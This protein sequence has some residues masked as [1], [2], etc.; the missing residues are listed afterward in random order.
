MKKLKEASALVTTFLWIALLFGSLILTGCA[1]PV[2]VRTLKPEAANRSLTES[3]LSDQSLSA[4]TQQVLNRSGLAEQFRK[5]PAA[6]IQALRSGMPTVLGSGRYFALAELSFL[7]ASEGGERSHYL[8][9][10]A[11]AYAFLFPRDEREVPDSFDPRLV[12]AVN[13][14]NQGLAMGF[15]SQ[16]SE[17]I[18]LQN[19][20]R[21]LPF[22]K[23]QVRFDPAERLWGPFNLS[24]FVASSSYEVRGL[25]ND[26]RWPGIGTAMVASLEQ[27]P[28]LEAPQF[29]LVPPRLKLAVTAFLRFENIEEGLESGLLSGELELFTSQEASQ[30]EV[31]GRKVPLEHRP[32]TALA[33]TLEGSKV[34]DL[35]LKGLLSGDLSFFQESARFKDN[36]FLMAPYRPGLIPLVLVHGTASSPAR[37]AELLNEIINDRELLQRYQIWLFTYNTGN[38]ILYSGGLLTQGLRNLVRELDPEGK[39]EALRK[40]VVIGHSQG[41]MLTRLTAID[42]GTRFWDPHFNV[43]LDQLDVS[44]E[45]RAMFQR[46][47]FYKPLPFVRRV[48]FISTPHRGSFLATNWVSS[49]LQ[50]V[51]TLPFTILSPFTEIFSKTQWAVKDARMIGNVPRSTDNMNPAH[52]FIQIFSSIPLAPRIAAH[53]IIAVD[54]PEDPQEEWSDGVVK[55][56]S[57]HVEGVASEHIVHSGHSAQENPQA[58]EEVRR[59]LRENLH[60]EGRTE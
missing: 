36:V 40:M 46:S 37:W 33:S 57:A 47:M 4:S 43:P 45:T 10:A 17:I 58:I 60:D 29:A 15:S 51:I 50:R 31:N 39:D 9:S 11:Y 27:V 23:L 38:P 18:H 34:Y 41:G 28:G 21:T 25:R 3:V 20:T 35:E 42:S 30:I 8:A 7:H 55:Y 1:T 54:N 24:N 13:L 52:P 49:M 32:T 59:I 2:G 14:Y 19:G 26:Y 5:E 22:G 53:S 12:T 16:E 48:I 6:T 56:S 44:V